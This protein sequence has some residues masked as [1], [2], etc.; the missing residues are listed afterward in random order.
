MRKWKITGTA[1]LTRPAMKE[2]PKPP[3]MTSGYPAVKSKRLKPLR[4]PRYLSMLSK[5]QE[6]TDS[7]RRRN[8][9]ASY[10]VKSKARELKTTKR[11]GEPLVDREG[12]AQWNLGVKLD[13]PD[14]EDKWYNIYSDN[15]EELEAIEWKGT[16]EGKIA[17][18]GSRFFL[19]S[20]GSPNGAQKPAQ[21]PPKPSQGMNTDR[22]INFQSARR[23]A[24][25]SLG[26]DA[27]PEAVIELAVRFADAALAY[28]EGRDVVQ[29]DS[30]PF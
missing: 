8:S 6:P 30:V 9:M 24:I 17:D 23:D 7:T 5:E 10:T 28:A 22:S 27:S 11:N 21:T 13:G 20:V 15:P 29:E 14:A 1:K 2:K 3:S 16:I 25:E 4:K 19:N 12:N 18:A 26:A